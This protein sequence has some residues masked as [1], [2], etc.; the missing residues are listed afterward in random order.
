MQCCVKK[1]KSLA[2]IPSD[3][4]TRRTFYITDKKNT[5]L[6]KEKRFN[7]FRIEPIFFNV[8][9]ATDFDTICVQLVSFSYS[10]EKVRTPINLNLSNVLYRSSDFN[11]IAI[12]AYAYKA[13]TISRV[14]AK[15]AK[16]YDFDFCEKIYKNFYNY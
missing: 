16:K 1:E 4:P 8:C 12:R 5:H 14:F 11:Q 15:I 3:T 13:N 9:S 7:P 10:Q 2:E 6:R